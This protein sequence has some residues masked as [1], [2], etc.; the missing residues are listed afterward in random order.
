VRDLKVER[1]QMT[2]ERVRL[3]CSERL[4]P[5]ELHT[6]VRAAGRLGIRRQA[7]DRSMSS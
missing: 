2:C 7:A 5:G 1:T 4:P 6:L 3:E